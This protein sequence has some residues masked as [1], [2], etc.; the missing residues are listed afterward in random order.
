MG[1]SDN[2]IK[3]IMAEKGAPKMTKNT[4]VEI[5]KLLAEISQGRKRSYVIDNIENEEGVR[6][7]AA[8][9]KDHRGGCDCFS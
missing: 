9:I 3:K 2:Q 6:C 7:V 1:L 4:I 8:S 5:D